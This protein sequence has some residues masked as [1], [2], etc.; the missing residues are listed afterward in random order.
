MVQSLS[1]HGCTVVHINGQKASKHIFA[2]KREYNRREKSYLL[3]QRRRERQRVETVTLP[4]RSRLVTENL[5]SFL[6]FIATLDDATEIADS[7]WLL[8]VICVSSTLNCL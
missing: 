3:T 2:A 8:I 4:N 7:F 6:F 1:W 5:S